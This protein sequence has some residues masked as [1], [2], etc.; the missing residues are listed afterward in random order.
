VCYPILLEVGVFVL[1]FPNSY[2]FCLISLVLFLSFFFFLFPLRF[3][4]PS[5]L[6]IFF[7]SLPFSK[8]FD[9]GRDS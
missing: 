1:F 5:P 4:F 6:F 2:V 3:F 9:F 8:I 7:A